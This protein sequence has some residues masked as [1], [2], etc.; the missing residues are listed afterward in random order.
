MKNLETLEK[1]L[2]L[3]EIIRNFKIDLIEGENIEDKNLNNLYGHFIKKV[4]NGYLL[5]SKPSKRDIFDRSKKEGISTIGYVLND[6]PTTKTLR[7]LQ[8]LNCINDGK[9][10]T[11]FTC[12]NCNKNVD[13][14]EI[15]ATSI[16]QL[17]VK[18]N[19]KCCCVDYIVD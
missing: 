7:E 11:K 17:S 4:N 2:N 19:N 12:N 14:T 5:Y 8:S 13:I 15:K 9:Y 16:E 10:D 1:E 18:L 6:L 3:I